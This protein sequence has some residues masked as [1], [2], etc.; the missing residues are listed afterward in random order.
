MAVH[1]V[2]PRSDPAAAGLQEPYADLRMLLAHPTPDHREA[3]Q[4]HL[5]RM[6][7]DVLCAAPGEAVDTYSGHSA[8]RSFMK[9]DREVEIFRRRPE[10]L[11]M[12]VIDHL[13]VIRV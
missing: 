5:H 12:R 9:A 3:G 13:A 4:H 1:A 6:R 2:E 8:R 7:D 11:E 10:R